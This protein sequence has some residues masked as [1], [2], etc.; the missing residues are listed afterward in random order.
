MKTDLLLER[1]LE[2]AED[3]LKGLDSKRIARKMSYPDLLG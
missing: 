3:R 2:E 1:H